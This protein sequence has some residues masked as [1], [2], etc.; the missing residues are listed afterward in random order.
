MSTE[1]SRLIATLPA[2]GLSR[3]Q[4]NQVE[5]SLVFK[6]ASHNAYQ[7]TS[8]P[9]GYYLVLRPQLLNEETGFITTKAFTVHNALIEPSGR[10]SAKRLN[11]ITITNDV[12][13]SELDALCERH[14]IQ[15][16]PAVLSAIA[17]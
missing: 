10:F 15:I 6:K 8:S 3:L 5:L 14:D 17:A 16:E 11:S 1:R 2:Q 9:S 12:L 13:K 7:G 4:V